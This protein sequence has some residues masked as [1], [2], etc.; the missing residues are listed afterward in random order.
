MPQDSNIHYF[1]FTSLRITFAAM[2]QLATLI[3]FWI[4]II[5]EKLRLR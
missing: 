3:R 2:K 4:Y 1:T 5:L